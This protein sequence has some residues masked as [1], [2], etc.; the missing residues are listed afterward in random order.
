MS[1]TEVV[2]RHTNDVIAQ[3]VEDSLKRVVKNPG[4]H[5]VTVVSDGAANMIKAASVLKETEVI[6]HSERC[7]AHRIHIA[8]S[9]SLPH[10]LLD[11]IRECFRGIRRV[12]NLL[13]TACD[14]QDLQEQSR[15]ELLKCIDQALTSERQE[16]APCFDEDDKA[17]FDGD[18]S[19]VA[20]LDGADGFNFLANVRD[21][22][23]KERHFTV[24]VRDVPTRW[25]STKL[26]LEC[27]LSFKNTLTC[28]GSGF[29]EED[30]DGVKELLP[31]LNSCVEK[32]VSF[33]GQHY[34]TF[35]HVYPSLYG[36][37]H[38][39][40]SKQ[41]VYEIAVRFR[42][43]MLT[44]LQD[45]FA[46]ILGTPGVVH[47]A[48]MLH[49]GFKLIKLTDA[50]KVFVNDYIRSRLPI[51]S[52]PQMEKKARVSDDY[53]DLFSVSRSAPVADI[54]DEWSR[55]LGGPEVDKNIDPLQW[56]SFNEVNFP[57]LAKIARNLLAIPA[58]SAASERVFSVA[59]ACCSGRR[60]GLNTETIETQILLRYNWE[61]VVSRPDF[62]LKSFKN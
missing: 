13:R 22:L 30:F 51:S 36:L 34:P 7:I 40:M 8:V 55:Y 48:A 2:S 14:R 26:L 57:E 41:P 38:Y 43:Q 10:Q 29:K 33:E 5:V 32:L 3:L 42:Q 23:Q 19:E 58:S 62:Y 35:C 11:R 27:F 37:R 9:K 46:N 61:L 1:L 4:R 20:K 50:M 17:N 18:V 16:K 45:A 53:G 56:W 39:L 44:E 60:S 47:V 24:P 49:P 59:N 25:T 54:G 12:Q 6:A 52:E 28:A 21:Q 15:S 31:M